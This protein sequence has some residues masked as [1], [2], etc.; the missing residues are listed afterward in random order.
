MI[1]EVKVVSVHEMK[2]WETLKEREKEEM[3]EQF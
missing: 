2:A 3:K 1:E